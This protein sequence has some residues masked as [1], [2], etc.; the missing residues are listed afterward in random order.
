VIR[1]IL[2]PGLALLLICPSPVP[3]ADT[4]ATHTLK[5]TPKTVAWGY[6]DAKAAPVLRINS[7][8]GE[9]YP[10]RRAI[11]WT[12]W[13]EKT[14]VS[15][16]RLRIVWPRSLSSSC[17]PCRSKRPK[18]YVRKSGAWRLSLPAAEV[19]EKLHGL[20]ETRVLVLYPELPQNLHKLPLVVTP[21]NFLQFTQQ[22]GLFF[23]RES[24]F[25][26]HT[27]ANSNRLL[28]P[29]LAV[30]VYT[31]LVIQEAA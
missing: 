9:L 31:Q 22:R 30:D 25:L 26:G 13:R 27:R 4:Q 19:A 18:P 6:C 1:Q 17:P 16:I 28:R 10:A 15:S 5:E 11:L 29:L 24:V 14:P 23:E 20:G 7:E 21:E 12:A 3:L 2:G 8:L